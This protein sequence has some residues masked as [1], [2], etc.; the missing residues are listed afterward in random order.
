MSAEVRLEPSW[1]LHTT[2]RGDTSLVLDLFTLG[3]GRQALM[4]RSARAARPA[5][6][7]LYQPF[8]PLLVSWAGE[9]AVRTLIGIEEAG[10]GVPG[11][12]AHALEGTA[13]ACAYYCNELV[14]RL[15]GK[16]EP[17]AEL[18][19]HYSLALAELGAGAEVETVLR[20]F[21]LQL[22]GATGTL[23]DLEF[24]VRGGARVD[25]GRRYRYH[26]ANAV[27]VEVRDET[28]HGRLKPERRG[29]DDGPGIADG[30]AAWHADGVTPDEGV[31]VAGAT[32]LAMARLDFDDPVVRAEARPLMKRV[33]HERLGG[34]GLNSRALFGALGGRATTGGNASAGEADGTGEADRSSRTDEGEGTDAA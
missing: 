21:E 7:A 31:E 22:L 1:I 2:A 13:L 32:L 14:L 34:R 23:P 11:G 30:D 10:E 24:A 9:G 27:A 4:A 25:P 29:L 20:T 33:L 6:R 3:H 26:V 12:G 28:V 5:V 8:R 16:G 15:L 17:Q 19:A 18:F